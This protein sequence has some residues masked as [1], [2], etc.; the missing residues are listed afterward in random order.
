MRK[1]DLLQ[2]GLKRIQHSLHIIINHIPDTPSYHTSTFITLCLRQ[3]ENKKKVKGDN[4]IFPN[5][6]VIPLLSFSS[7]A[8][9]FTPQ[10]LSRE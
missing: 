6:S 9:E 3:K 7:L 2:Q 5:K 1:T 8:E 4:N 10:I